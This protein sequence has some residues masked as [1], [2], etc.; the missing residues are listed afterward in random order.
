[1]KR[2]ERKI[3]RPSYDASVG[4][5]LV[6]I[7]TGPAAPHLSSSYNFLETFPCLV[8]YELLSPDLRINSLL[9]IS[10]H[11][12]AMASIEL[13]TSEPAIGDFV[14]LAEHQAQTPDTFF[15][16]KPVL[17]FHCTGALITIAKDQLDANVAISGLIS[18]ETSAAEGAPPADENA[19]SHSASATGTVDVWVTSEC[20]L[21]SFHF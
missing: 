13:I 10:L 3:K 19:P 5:C 8:L 12:L 15:H 1:M 9:K 11:N 17:Y 21:F 20:V 4:F 14:P 2:V 16:G 7:R 18:S 6:P